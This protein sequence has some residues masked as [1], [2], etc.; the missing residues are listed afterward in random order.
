MSRRIAVGDLL[1]DLEVPEDF[2]TTFT[3]SG[4]VL[5]SRGPLAYEVS[6]LTLEGDEGENSLGVQHVLHLAVGEVA[7]TGEVVVATDG[8]AFFAG[9]GN[10]VLVATLTCPEVERLEASALLRQLLGT[11]APAHDT[12]GPATESPQF[13]PLRDSQQPW[14]EHARASLRATLGWDADGLLPPE[15]LDALWADLQVEPPD[16][17][18]G[19]QLV[20]ELAVAFGDHLVAAGFRWGVAKDVFGT[21]LAVMALE[22][23]ARVLVDPRG[24]VSKRWHRKEAPFFAE[25]L[26]QIRAHVAAQVREWARRLN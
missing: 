17:E 7:R 11:A 6:T 22:D 25:A 4:S 3:D 23:T 14:L 21:T 18:F 8:E 15:E 24:F 16:A 9:L 13:S 10:R 12:F 19:E 26:G 5:F 20:S 1:V 2:T